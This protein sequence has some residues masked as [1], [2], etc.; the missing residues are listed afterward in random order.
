MNISPLKTIDTSNYCNINNP[1]EKEKLLELMKI[2][3][4]AEVFRELYPELK[5]ISWRQNNPLKQ[6]RL[7]MILPSCSRIFN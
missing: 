7:S 4:L 2:Y 6:A 1:K 3:N 5:R